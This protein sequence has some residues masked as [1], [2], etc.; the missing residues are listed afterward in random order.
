MKRCPTCNRTYSDET[1]TFCLAD[2]SLLSAPYDSE[3]TQRIPPP[4]ITNHA[5]TEVLPSAQSSSQKTQRSSNPLLY[6]IVILLALI[7]G[8]GVVALIKSGNKETTPITSPA[9]ST[10][11]PIPN[12]EQANT[13][14]EGAA[15]QNQNSDSPPLTDAG[16]RNLINRWLLAQNSKNITA[17]QSCYG[18]SFEGIKRTASGRSTS[19]NFNAWMKDRWRMISTADGLNIEIKNMRINISGDT[20]IVE[21][22]QYYRANKY[23][24]WG[25]KVMKVKMSPTGEK[26]VYEE[27]KAS[28]PLS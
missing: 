7:L 13:R 27:L 5:P 10:P 3:A 4:R 15:N 1:L 8:G 21:F 23:S 17:Y 26:I 9:T 2:G 22:D 24:D 28:Y 11:T 20:A 14:E 25:P 12:K 19:Y 16:V 6:I 18:A